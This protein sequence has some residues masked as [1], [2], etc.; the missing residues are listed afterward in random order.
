MP[1]AI[2][3]LAGRVLERREKVGTLLSKKNS[4]GEYDW[5]ATDHDNFKA[6]NAELKEIVPKLDNLRELA[7]FEQKNREDIAAMKAITNELPF[8]MLG[9]S[10]DPNPKPRPMS[11]ADHLLNSPAY[12]SWSGSPN[13][14]IRCIGMKTSIDDSYKAIMLETGA[15]FS[16]Q[17]NRTPVVIYSAQRKPRVADL[18][19]S[20]NTENQLIRYML[21]TT[22]TNAA[23]STAEGGS[24][25]FSSLAFTEQSQKV[26]AVATYI[27]ATNQQLKDVSELRSIIDNRLMLMMEQTEEVEILTGSGSSPHLAGLLNVS[28]INTQAKGGLDRPDAFLLAMTQIRFN[29]GSNAGFAEPSGVIVHPTDWTNIRLTKD[30]IGNYLWGSPSQPGDA[31]IWGL[32]VIETPVITVGTAL[33]GDFRMFAHISRRQ[34]IDIEAGWINDDFIKGQN[35]IRAVSRLSLETYRP[36]AFCTITGL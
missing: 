29:T 21:E 34:E 7:R 5:D 25:P 24:M 17:N 11:L 12:K 20:S 33:A 19:P 27:A 22:F 23:A 15:G 18:I 6:I 31:V 4:K 26:E 36:A 10:Q 35:S 16:P 1:T 9:S 14:M 3:E 30:A 8:G 32:P 13:E 28:G 2:E